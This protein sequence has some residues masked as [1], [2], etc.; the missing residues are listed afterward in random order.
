MVN[1]KKRISKS[2][3]KSQ[4]RRKSRSKK[5]SAKKSQKRRKSSSKKSQKRRKSSSKKSQKR[6][7]SRSKKSQKRRKNDGLNI[8]GYNFRLPGG[9]YITEK[10]LDEK[11]A[12]AASDKAKAASDKAKADVV[13]MTENLL[14]KP[15]GNV[16]L[17]KQQFEKTGLGGLG[18]P[19]IEDKKLMDIL[20]NYAVTG[21]I[22]NQE[23]FN[24]YCTKNIKDIDSCKKKI[25]D[26]IKEYIS[27]NNDYLSKLKLCKASDFQNFCNEEIKKRKSKMNKVENK[28]F[29][30]MN[31][32]VGKAWRNEWSK[33]YR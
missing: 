21:E 17:L 28:A 6:G 32:V 19:K 7:K 12:K 15:I 31:N 11:N 24:K 13:V 23:I 3:K 29:S 2:Q 14:F 18:A 10:S 16:A 25:Q 22:N 4:K 30:E 33:T 27:N 5:V 1:R 8:F 20:K 26:Y 9:T